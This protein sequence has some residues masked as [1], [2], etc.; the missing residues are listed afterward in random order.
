MTATCRH[1]FAAAIDGYSL[2]L[3]HR[4]LVGVRWSRG[5]AVACLPGPPLQYPRLPTAVPHRAQKSPPAAKPGGRYCW[6][7]RLAQALDGGAQALGH[8]ARAQDGERLE[9]V[10]A[11]PGAGHGHA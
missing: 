1:Y 5:R 10:G 8:L 3:G 4:L 9:E 2:P 7:V 11:G 6:V